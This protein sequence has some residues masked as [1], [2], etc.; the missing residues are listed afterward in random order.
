MRRITD[1]RKYAFL[2]F[3]LSA[4]AAFAVPQVTSISPQHGFTFQSTTVTING[5]DFGP[6]AVVMFG[7][8]PGTVLEVLPHRIT[9][10]APSRPSGTRVDVRIRT[11]GQVI[12]LQ[13]AFLHDDKAQGNRV[14]YVQY[15]VPVTGQSMPGAHGSLWTTE[16]T[17][18]NASP[19]LARMIWAHCPP[20][21]S[22]CPLPEVGPMTTARLG[23][24]PS[25]GNGRD[26]AF[27]YV[28]RLLAEQTAMSLRVRDL[29]QSANF[30]T[31]VPVVRVES[32]FTNNIRQV[33]RLID[34]PTDGRFRA[35]LRIY[36]FDQA[37]KQVN[38]RILNER[39]DVLVDAPVNLAGVVTAA[40]D[41]F[42]LAPAYAQ[43]DPLTPEVRAAGTHIRIE[44]SAM[45]DHLL[46]PPMVHPI[47]AF[48][49]LTNNETQQ[50]TTVRPNL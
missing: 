31:E 15:L 20:T 21:A 44:L 5:S 43:F 3:L 22:P 26:G 27:V 37:P 18:F 47:W 1:M 4:G 45:S 29:H 19:W 11:G 12:L 32:E 23:A 8:N 7:D 39:N 50:V 36:S 33:L 2:L 24:F 49:T 46:S 41:P 17:V 48:V 40:F 28:P 13:N 14:D 6:D 35:T 34:I 38:L 16:W 25:I 9:V 10:L 42:P 30:G